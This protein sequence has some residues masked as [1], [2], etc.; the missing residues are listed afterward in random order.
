MAGRTTTNLPDYPSKQSFQG[1]NP[2]S[3]SISQKN[4]N[5]QS[6]NIQSIDDIKTP[7]FPRRSSTFP[8]Q[9]ER[10]GGILPSN[11]Q[12]AS[13]ATATSLHL[14]NYGNHVTFVIQ[15]PN[16]SR[17]AGNVNSLI[18]RDIFI[19][20]LT[21][22]MLNILKLRQVKETQQRLSHRTHN[23]TKLLTHYHIFPRISA[24]GALSECLQRRHSHA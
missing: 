10:A 23:I 21:Q 17:S 24:N 8:Q 5:R 3:I 22:K 2:L 13:A 7:T 6:S 1:V 20:Q 19:D 16:S 14:S 15:D 18:F 4:R 11:P 9:Q 12:V